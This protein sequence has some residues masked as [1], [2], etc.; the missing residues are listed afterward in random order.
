[1]AFADQMAD[2]IEVALL[3]QPAGL[4]QMRLAFLLFQ[5]ADA[6]NRKR[7]AGRFLARAKQ[8]GIYTTVNDHDLIAHIL[9]AVL[10]DQRFVVFRYRH[11]KRGRAHLLLEHML[12]NI[13]IVRVRGEAERNAGQPVRCQRRHRRVIGEMRVDMRHA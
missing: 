13:Q 10:N 4:D 1:M 9:A 11:H 3:E 12:I 5:R 7:A 8:A 6:H 2:E